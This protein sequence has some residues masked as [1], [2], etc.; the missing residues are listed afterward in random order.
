MR[1]FTIVTGL[2]LTF[3]AIASADVASER[4]S[5]PVAT[6]EVT[7]GWGVQLGDTEYLPNGTST[8]YKYPFVSGFAGGA[9]VGW[10]FLPDLAL[11]GSYET[12][13]ASSVD[14]SVAGAIDRVEGA[15]RYQTATLGFRLYRDLG[16][17]RLR[18]Q[19]SAG[20][21]FPFETTTEYD[22]GP[23]LAPAGIT[24]TGI[25]TERYGLGYGAE[26]QLGYELALRGAM[27]ISAALEL[28]AFQSDNKGKDMTLDNMV[29][30]FSAPTAIDATMTHD[31]PTTYSVQDLGLRLGV[32]ARF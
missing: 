26:T 10:L 14:G 6:A 11:V 12:W 8:T 2:F 24:G 13:I 19:M 22:W 23:A 7:G 17:G 1:T 18:A 21:V 15:V 16:P 5:P 27:F 29:M 30:D 25:T 32:G 4:A 28:R 20:L 31:Q 9:S 3:P